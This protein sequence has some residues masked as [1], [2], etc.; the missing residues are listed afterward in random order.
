MSI[1][2]TTRGLSNRSKARSL[3][4]PV[5]ITFVSTPV[6]YERVNLELPKDT[7]LQLPRETSDN[8]KE[9]RRSGCASFL[10]SMFSSRHQ[11]FR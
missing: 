3:G 10:W 1:E 2:F 6:N 5:R 9:R 7:Q 11:R 8:D 4:E